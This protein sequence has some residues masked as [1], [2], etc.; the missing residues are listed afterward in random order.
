M[1]VQIT[2]KPM[3]NNG[4]Q[5]RFVMSHGLRHQSAIHQLTIHPGFFSGVDCIVRSGGAWRRLAENSLQRNLT[6]LQPNIGN[7]S[8]AA[9]STAA[10]R[11]RCDP[12]CRSP[13]RRSLWDRFTAHI[14]NY[15]A[16]RAAS[17]V[18]PSADRFAACRLGRPTAAPTA[19]RPASK[20]CSS[21]SRIAACSAD[22]AG[23]R[24]AEQL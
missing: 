23:F 9:S 7:I 11:K 14:R 20:S 1:F 19:W 3:S 22:L 21:R 5:L 8:R 15:P 12:R 18:R 24:R 16:H 10:R 4:R 6:D 13:N 17:P 2:I